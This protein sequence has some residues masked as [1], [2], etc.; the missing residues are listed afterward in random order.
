MSLRAVAAYSAAWPAIDRVTRLAV[1]A[2]IAVGAS[3]VGILVTLYPSAVPL[4]ASAV[5]VGVLLVSPS[6]RFAFVTFGGL[7]MLQGADE[8]DT[9]KSAYLVG[10]ALCVA[11][12]AGRLLTRRVR[13]PQGMR[14]VLL[15][16]GCFAGYLT[17][18]A[19]VGVFQDQPIV[20]MLRGV[21]P[22][23]LFLA[24][25]LLSLDAIGSTVHRHAWLA[26]VGLGSVATLVYVV[27]WITLRSLV[28]TDLAA[29]GVASPLAAGALFAALSAMAA[30]PTG[31]TG[32]ATRAGCALLAG[33][34]LGAMLATGSRSNIVLL[35]A[36]IGMLLVAGARRR[37]VAMRLGMLLALAA[38]TTAMLFALLD[39]LS[40]FDSARL[41]DRLAGLVGGLDVAADQSYIERAAQTQAAVAAIGAHPVFGSGLNGSIEFVRANGHFDQVA[42]IDSLLIVPFQ[43]GVVGLAFFMLLLLAWTVWALRPGPPA[44]L[45][46]GRLTLAGLW[47]TVL[48]W[49][50]LGSPI[51]DKG[52]SLVLVGAAL[53]ALPAAPAASRASPREVSAL[54]IR[55]GS[56]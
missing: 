30:L 53:L 29:V 8:L 52:F 25:P 45:G 32:V 44:A 11:I 3:G 24:A 16:S 28:T 17:L 34:T 38:G 40:W 27:H 13:L 22:Y 10:F 46:V 15:L 9:G 39:S 43:T 2:A 56:T 20:A 5:G 42:V 47:V 23:G 48:V 4:G 21:A 35:V 49:C 51:H 41:L 18:V 14:P 36:P 55:V 33:L 1:G 6:A 31:E 37:S 50:L 12:S 26:L 19:L 54:S 7:V